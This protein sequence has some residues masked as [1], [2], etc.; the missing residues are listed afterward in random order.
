M[1]ACSRCS[2][3]S[4]RSRRSS[5][6]SP[7][8]PRQA[9]ARYGKWLKA[10]PLAVEVVSDSEKGLI[11]DQHSMPQ[12]DDRMSGASPLDPSWSP[13]PQLSATDAL[14]VA[15]PGFAF[16]APPTAAPAPAPAPAQAAVAPLAPPLAPP[17]AAPVAPPV[18]P[19]A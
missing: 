9:A 14:E 11:V 12:P 13:P 8:R 15:Q 19:P 10:T 2:Q 3:A 5:G 16:S 17:V 1:T 4:P 7:E 18:A 6:S